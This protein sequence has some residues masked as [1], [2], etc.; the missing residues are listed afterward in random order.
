MSLSSLHV[1]FVFSTKHRK[2]CITPDLRPRLHA[3]LGGIARELKAKAVIVNGT[4]DHVHMLVTIPATASVADLA[5]VLKA[6][7]SRWAGTESRVAKRL[8][9]IYRQHVENAGRSRVHS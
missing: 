5:R 2:P 7:S 4:A 8:C 1:H 6:N 3:Y 9:C